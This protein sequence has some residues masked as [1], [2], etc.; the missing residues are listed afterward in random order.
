M[1]RDLLGIQPMAA[2]PCPPVALKPTDIDAQAILRIKLMEG[3]QQPYQAFPD[4]IVNAGIIKHSPSTTDEQ[5]PKNAESAAVFAPVEYP[6]LPL[7]GLKTSSGRSMLLS[8]FEGCFQMPNAE[9]TT[10]V[11]S[12][13]GE[14]QP[15]SMA[16]LVA[17][18]MIL[19]DGWHI[20][21][22]VAP[23]NGTL[24]LPG[25]GFR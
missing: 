23:G 15:L 2:P 13:C 9:I 24:S 6:L 19:D 11:P 20:L 18:D 14:R 5:Q 22:V 8:A 7:T 10:N 3:H 4:E 16:Q 17:K 1:Q 25:E 21:P 12:V